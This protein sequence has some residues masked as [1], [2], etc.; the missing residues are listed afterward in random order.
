MQGYEATGQS[1]MYV[2]RGLGSCLGLW[3]GG[4]A[5]DTIGPRIMYRVSACVALVGC[6][7]F[8][9]VV[10]CCPTTASEPS[11]SSGRR[12]ELVLVPTEDDTDESMMDPSFIDDEESSSLQ[13]ESSVELTELG[14]T[15]ALNR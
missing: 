2:A 1:F 12:S 11:S 9:W 8:A 6:S 3:L 4:R 15:A 13:G 7:A 5:M 14:G 10:F